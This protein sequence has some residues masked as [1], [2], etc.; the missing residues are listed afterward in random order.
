MEAKNPNVLFGGAHAQALAGMD[1]MTKRGFNWLDDLSS[2]VRAAV[3]AESRIRT[4]PDGAVLYRQGDITSEFFQIVS[5][6]IRKF[7]LKEDGQEVLLYIYSQ[8]DMV[9]DSSAI[10]RDPFPVT[11]ATRGATALRV[12]HVDD[13]NYL[14]RSYP[15]IDAGLALQTSRRLRSTLLLIEELLTLPVGPRIAS[16]IASLADLHL[17]TS[18]GVDLDLSQA[19]LALMAGTTRQS[20]NHTVHELKRLG[21][22]ETSYGKI[23]VKDLEGLRRYIDKA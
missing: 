3:I 16:R 15:Q 9:A 1:P 13:L 2:D 14:R 11:I 18:G 22:I 23:L 19:D 17:A 5:G 10:D 21:L 12:W 7:V 6:E 8:G 20:V 4:Y